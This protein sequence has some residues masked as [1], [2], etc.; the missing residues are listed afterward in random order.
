MADTSGSILWHRSQ[1]EASSLGHVSFSWNG[2][3]A[4]SGA[5]TLISKLED[6]PV[7]IVLAFDGDRSRFSIKNAL[8]SELSQLLTGE[9]LL[10]A[11]LIYT[12][13][14]TSPAGEVI[15]NDQTGGIRKLLVASGDSVYNQWQ[16]YERDVRAGFQKAFGEKNLAP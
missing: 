10:Y 12:W 16:K 11:T 8:L 14:R 7:G 13:S 6:V 15:A 5:H 4:V 9:P 2:P 1:L 3:G